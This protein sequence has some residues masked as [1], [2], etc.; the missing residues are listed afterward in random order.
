MSGPSSGSRRT[1]PPSSCGNGS[2]IRRTAVSSR[3]G[4]PSGA[5]YGRFARYYDAIY[6]SVVDYNGD[7]RFL[8]TVFKRFH[9]GKP[10]RLLDLGC[11][12]GNHAIPLARRGHVVTGVDRSS[13]MLSLARKKAAAAN[14]RIRFARG[15]MT[16]FELGATFDA[17]VCMF[18]AFGYVLGLPDATRCLR[19]VRR[20]LSPDGLFVY[21]FWQRS[22]VHTG[23]DRTWLLRRGPQAEIVR[24][25]EEDFNRRTGRLSVDFRFFVFRGRRLID[26][27]SELHIIQM[28]T[29]EGMRN[30]LRRGGFKPLGFFAATN[31]R[32]GFEPPTKKTFRVMAVAR[33]RAQS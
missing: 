4:L 14:L 27:F 15:D 3:V 9:S 28:Y 32:K 12:T 20:H 21:E 13:S 19:R 16:T 24:L 29:I 25:A 8:E 7:V 22:A 5:T 23:P 31:L 1:T 26:R 11:G 33:A 6:D 2:I 10:H 17:T 18:G 30:L